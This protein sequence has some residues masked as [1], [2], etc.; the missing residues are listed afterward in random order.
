VDLILA[1]S[2]IVGMPGM[3]GLA[4]VHAFACA[5]PYVTIQSNLHSP[6]FAY[7]ADGVNG[8]VAKPH[9]Q[10]FTEALETLV[11]DPLLRARMGANGREFALKELSMEKQ[12]QG[13]LQAFAYAS[14]LG[15][16][17]RCES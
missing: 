10:G 15:A 3:T 16:T 11:S 8:L 4:V 9:P 13:F 5:K 14:K 1:A 17:Q 2:D 7:L 12:V 6:E